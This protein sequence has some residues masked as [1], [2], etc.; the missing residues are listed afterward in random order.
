MTDLDSPG[1]VVD[2]L[3][4][5][6]FLAQVSQVHVGEERHSPLRRHVHR[7]TPTN[8]AIVDTE[9]TILQS[10]ADPGLSLRRSVKSMLPSGY[11]TA[12]A[13]TTSKSSSTISKNFALLAC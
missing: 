9:R 1:D 13:C 5:N 7:L 10:G 6:H 4:E 3:L 12:L 8:N 11:F 2:A